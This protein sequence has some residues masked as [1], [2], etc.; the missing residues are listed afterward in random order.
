MCHPER[1]KHRKAVCVVELLRVERSEQAKAQGGT[2]QRDPRRIT[3]DFT[4]TNVTFSM[5][6]QQNLLRD[7][8]V[9]A[10]GGGRRRFL[11]FGSARFAPTPKLRP[12]S[13]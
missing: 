13:L 10:A 7:P 9:T 12:A 3:V 2:P 11:G 6:G 4:K 5:Q 8:C 1:S